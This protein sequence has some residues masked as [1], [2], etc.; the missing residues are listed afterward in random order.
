MLRWMTA[1]ESH[2]EALTAV[3]EGVSAGV[4]I[5]SEDIRAALARRRLGHGRGARQ[6]FERDELRVLGG[7]RHGSTIGSPVALQIANSEWP[8]WSTVMSCTWGTAWCRSISQPG[9]RAPPASAQA[10]ATAV[11]QGA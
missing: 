9:A 3:L 11:G 8:K 1:G 4:R 6:A 5:T 2:G 10:P 7:I